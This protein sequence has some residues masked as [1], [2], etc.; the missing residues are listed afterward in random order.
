[1]TPQEE[2]L[3]LQLHAKWGN[4]WSRIARCLPGRTDNEI[5]NYW[6]THM[7]KKAQER[8]MS[9][10]PWSPSSSSSHGSSSA[11]ESKNGTESMATEGSSATAGLE[12]PKVYSMDQIWDEIAELGTEQYKDA[13][14]SKVCSPPPPMAFPAWEES[15]WKEADYGEE[16]KMPTTMDDPL[17]GSN[18][19]NWDWSS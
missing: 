15:L 19:Q 13:V 6:R 18:Y 11:D 16:I 9:S 4:R 10:P 7:R 2:R 12:G 8:S 5:K 14:C 3:V 1:M 17:M